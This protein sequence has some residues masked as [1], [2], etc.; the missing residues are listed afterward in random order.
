MRSKIVTINGKKVT[1]K[2][3]RIIELREEIAPKIFG[4]FDGGLEGL[5]TADLIP[6]LEEKV[7]E[8]FPELSPEDI[9]NAFP[10]ELEELIQAFIDVNFGG[11]KKIL[12]ALSGLIKV[13]MS[14]VASISQ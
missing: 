13:G 5:D 14:K 7:S 9:D 3:K 6:F 11:I 2:E 12:P 10:S 8:I 4:I 1:V